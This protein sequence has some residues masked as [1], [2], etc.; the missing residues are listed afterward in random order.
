MKKACCLSIL[1]LQGGVSSAF[2]PLQFGEGDLAA[3]T[4]NVA[5]LSQTP[6]ANLNIEMDNLCASF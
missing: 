5:V 1:A 3:A 4:S 6:S 2:A